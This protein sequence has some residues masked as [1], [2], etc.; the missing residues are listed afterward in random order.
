VSAT[1]WVESALRRHGLTASVILV[2]TG[3][4]LHIPDFAMSASMGFRMVGMGF[5]PTMVLG[6]TLIVLGL[7][8]GFI[9]AIIGPPRTSDGMGVRV[10]AMDDRRLGWRDL[11][12]FS[13]LGFGL[14]IDIMKP[15]TIGFVIPGA[16]A[17]YGLSLPQITL[18]PLIALSG[19]T[20]GSVMWGVLGDRIGRRASVLLA[21]LLFIATSVCGAMPA[22]WLNLVMCLIMGMSVGGMLPLVF[23]LLAEVVPRVHRGWLLV[24]LGCVAGAGGYVAATSAAALLEPHFGWRALWLVGLPTGIMLLAFSG[25]IPESPRFLALAGRVDEAIRQ[26]ARLGARVETYDPALEPAAAPSTVDSGL[27]AGHRR[28]LT[29][30]IGFFGL[31]WGLVNFGV[32]TWL[33][34]LLRATGGSATRWNF[35]L[36]GAALVAVP[37]SLVAALLYGRWR[38]RASML[39]FAVL[40]A[41][42][43]AGLGAVPVSHYQ[44][45][46]F[47]G[48]LVLL[49]TGLAGTNAMLGVYAAE[50]FPT[51]IR[52]SGAGLQAAATKSGGI[53]GPP[54]VAIIVSL[55]PGLHLTA[56]LLA[57]PLAVAAFVVLLVGRETRGRRLEEI[58]EVPIRP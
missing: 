19:T 8:V 23:A 31:A 1:E 15:A 2:A 37:G 6:M 7:A 41:L 55:S 10:I 16:R 26:M 24:T 52:S 49:L 27:F 45:P 44:E 18:W 12:L 54:L 48:L 47:A 39:A 22:Y 57:V 42:A 58:T 28:A 34:T 30:A 35:L 4:C 13:V 38:S 33:P 17:E 3:V 53:V 46:L 5:T 21:G 9:A 36:A 25:F 50:V 43:L 20:L 11:A 56:W 29:A 14:V 32:L 51:V 40:A